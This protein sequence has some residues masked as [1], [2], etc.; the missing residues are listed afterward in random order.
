MKRHLFALLLAVVG[1]VAQAQDFSDSPTEALQMTR[2]LAQ[3][4]V[5]DPLRLE[6]LISIMIRYNEFRAEVAPAGYENVEWYQGQVRPVLAAIATSAR[7][8]SDVG[9]LGE[10][11]LVT[12]ASAFGEFGGNF[13]RFYDEA[14]GPLGLSG[15]PANRFLDY[16]GGYAH[17]AN[18]ADPEAYQALV[19]FTGIWPLCFWQF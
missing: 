15:I 12:M 8:V 16:L 4:I 10:E 19:S 6:G 13:F 18:T 3:E 11:Q 7:K 17:I 1:S 2:E 5:S 14:Q 9:P